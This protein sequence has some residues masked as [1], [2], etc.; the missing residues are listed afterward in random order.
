VS[1]GTKTTSELADMVREK[2]AAIAEQIATDR[3]KALDYLRD[4]AV[5]VLLRGAYDEP[6]YYGYF[7]SEAE[8]LDY[9][10]KLARKWGHKYGFELNSMEEWNQYASAA[11]RYS[12][13]LGMVR[14]PYRTPPPPPPA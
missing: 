1:L 2:A 13:V 14:L 9:A 7:H 11:G 12:R 8:L 4:G 10:A 3:A 5:Y 6:M